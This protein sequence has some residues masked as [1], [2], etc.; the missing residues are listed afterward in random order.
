MKILKGIWRKY[1]LYNAFLLLLLKMFNKIYYYNY[2]IIFIIW[3]PAYNLSNQITDDISKKHKINNIYDCKI[4]KSEFEHFLS[5]V[6]NIDNKNYKKKVYL[7]YERLIENNCLIKVLEVNFKM[8]T[9]EVQDILNNKR[10]VDAHI[11]KD[12]IRVKYKKNINN[13]IFD[14]IIHST[15]T[16]KQS[17]RLK[18]L[19]DQFHY[20]E[21]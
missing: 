3:P 8:P 6:Y 4:K 11:L 21:N 12:F 2:K 20:E 7:K 17:F 16:Q 5:E 14:I 15:E 13:Y 9:I 19:I 1:I 18:K 10:C